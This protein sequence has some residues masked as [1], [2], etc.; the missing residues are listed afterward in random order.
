MLITDWIYPFMNSD[1]LYTIVSITAQHGVTL[2]IPK[3]TYMSRLSLHVCSSKYK[4]SVI[5][6]AQAY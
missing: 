5:V 1:K 4:I 3:F 2:R 6:I